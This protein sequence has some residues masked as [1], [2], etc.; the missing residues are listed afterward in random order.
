LLEAILSWSIR[1]RVLVIAAAVAVALA[2]TASMLGLP[3]DAVPDITP[4]Q[5]QVVTVSPALG[6]LEME[7]QVTVPVETSLAGTPGLVGLRSISKFGVSVVTAVFG[8]RTDPWFAR[9]LVAERIDAAE[10]P[11]SAG[12]PALGPPATGLGEVYQYSL[13]GP[14]R[15]LEELRTIQD[16]I[17]RP[18]LRAVPGVADVSSFGGFVREVH[19]V[20]DPLRLA[21]RG[22]SLGR[23]REAFGRGAADVGGGFALRGSEQA[24]VRGLGRLGSPA[25]AAE[26]VVAVRE[27]VP[28]RVRDVAEVRIGHEIRQGAVT[29]DGR[30]EVVAGIVL[31]LQG[32][33][34]RTVV[35]RVEQAVAALGPRLPAGVEVRSFYDRASLID[36]VIGT[37]T[38]NLLEA[39]VVVIAVLLLLLGHLRAG[40]IVALAIPLS[41]LFAFNLMLGVGVSASLMSLGA[42]DFGLLVDSSVILVENCMRRLAGA[43]PGEDTR[44][45]VRRA[46]VEVRGPTM[47]GELII[48]AVYVPV[49]ALEGVEGRMFRP[50]ALTVIFALAGSLL[51]S[52]T[53]TPALAATLLRGPGGQ[54]H[55]ETAPVRWARGAYAPFLRAALAAPVAVAGAAALVVAGGALLAARLGTEFIPELDEGAI[56]MNVVRL[57]SVALEASAAHSGLVERLLRAE[58]PDEVE[59]VVSKIGRAEVAYDPMGPELADVFV[60]LRPRQGWKRAGNRAELAARIGEALAKVPGAQHSFSQPIELRMNEFVAGVRADLAVRVHGPD[61]ETLRK[62]AEEVQAV[63]REVPGVDGT[64]AVEV[65]KG[66]PYLE[67]RPDRAA[68]AASGVDAAAILEVV[69]CMGGVT[70]ADVLEGDWRVPLVVILPEDVRTDRAALEALPVAGA[71]GTAVPLSRVAEIREVEGPAQVSRL[72]GSRTISVSCDVA[73]RDLGSFVADARSRIESRVRLLPGYHFEYGGQF[74]NFERA[75]RR[76][77]VVVPVVLAI[78]LGLLAWSFGALA[79]AFLVFS[80]VPLAA[81]GGVLALHLRGLHFSISAAVGFIALFGVAVLNGLVLVSFV[82]DLAARGTQWRAA[83]EEGCLARLRPVLTTALV[84]SLG[85]LPMALSTGPGAEVQRPLATVVIGGLLTST[86]LTLLV[87]PA[88]LLLA[89]PGRSRPR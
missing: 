4:V 28:V 16:R 22:V 12:R 56:A 78:V 82:R 85:F 68:A 5:V 89:G 70:V 39:A 10:V 86:A 60:M 9:R 38:T 14:G 26:V 65:V 46:A 69:E 37:V 87:L 54:A 29:R 11:A 17:V 83:V 27:E 23:L 3:I 67:V 7:R 81:V 77:S 34:S 53:L 72:A 59:T 20:A 32:E 50:M 74:E 73:G 52:L 64:P 24:I 71:D 44:E 58:F 1:R 21:S 48:M 76:L 49:L 25:E 41:M 33:N 88:L 63:L 15:S 36:R 62:A 30:G 79:P 55:G 43:A 45:V 61:M 31:M 35:H 8:D 47:F 57:P 2:G 66:L 19:V 75:R 51:L 6:P 80:G 42:I 13:E 40:V 84:A 18:A